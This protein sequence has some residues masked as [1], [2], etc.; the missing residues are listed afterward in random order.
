VDFTGTS[1]GGCRLLVAVLSQYKVAFA[2]FGSSS[3]LIDVTDGYVVSIGVHIAFTHPCYAPLSRVIQPLTA[4]HAVGLNQVLWDL[5]QHPIE[6][7][8]EAELRGALLIQQA[9]SCQYALCHGCNVAKDRRAVHYAVLMRALGL[10]CPR[11]GPRWDYREI[12]QPI[13]KDH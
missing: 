2:V 8:Q 9:G 1:C 13:N 12:Y 3:W 6:L 7:H 10:W 5:M 11:L 4:V